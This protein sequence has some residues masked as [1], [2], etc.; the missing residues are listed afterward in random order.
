MD[1]LEKYCIKRLCTFIPFI[2]VNSLSSFSLLGLIRR[3]FKTLKFLWSETTS[4]LSLIYVI[5]SVNQ[6]LEAKTR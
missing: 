6:M 4:L 2:L 5:E 1:I 3:E